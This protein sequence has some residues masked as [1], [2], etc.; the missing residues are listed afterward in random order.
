M[1]FYLAHR[2][3]G[4]FYGAAGFGNYGGQ[5]FHQHRVIVPGGSETFA[6]GFARGFKFTFI[7]TILIVLLLPFFLLMK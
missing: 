6:E 2:L 3:P 5:H 1:R 4:G 7:A